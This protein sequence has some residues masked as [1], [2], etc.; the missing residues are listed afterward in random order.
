MTDEER[1]DTRF[2]HTHLRAKSAEELNA[3]VCS[4]Q[5]SGFEL[6]NVVYDGNEWHAF[7]R[8]NTCDWWP[9]IVNELDTLNV[10]VGMLINNESDFVT[11]GR[12]N[13]LQSV[14]ECI[15]RVL[16]SRD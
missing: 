9:D 10:G 12:L 14:V 11:S 13:D 16:E 4:I 6:V 2:E 1:D 5:E 15:L 7:M 3:E 8:R